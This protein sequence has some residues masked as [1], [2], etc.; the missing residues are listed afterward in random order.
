MRII[1]FMC[2]LL[3]VKFSNA[4]KQEVGKVLGIDSLKSKPGFYHIC[5]ELPTGVLQVVGNCPKPV[6]DSALVNE[7][8]LL[9]YA[10]DDHIYLKPIKK[11]YNVK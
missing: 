3:S 10:K 1:I 2:L 9:T 6:K 11:I 4:Q 5:F 8:F 7:F